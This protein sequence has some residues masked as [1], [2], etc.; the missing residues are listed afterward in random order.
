VKLLCVHPGASFSTADVYNGLTPALA[1][2]GHDI[3][4]YRLDWRINEATEIIGWRERRRKKAQGAD[5]QELPGGPMPHIIRH[6][7]MT[8]LEATLTVNPH[9]LLIFSAMF[10]H[11]EAMILLRR[12]GVPTV[13]LLTESP[14]DDAKQANITPFAS[15]VYTNERASVRLMRRWHEQTGGQ[16]GARQIDYLPHAYDPSVH[17]PSDSDRHDDADI[18]AHDVVFVGS[19]FYERQEVLQAVDWEGLY[20]KWPYVGSRNRLRRYIRGGVVPNAVTA[21][22]YRRARI[23]LNLYRQSVGTS[24]N[25]TR[26]VG[27]ESLNPRALELAATATPHISDWRPEVEEVFGDTVPTFRNA[28]EL[29]TLIRSLMRPDADSHLSRMRAELPDR[30]K[31]WTFDDRAIQVERGIEL[32]RSAQP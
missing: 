20:G 5:Y 19:G 28:R 23:G 22:L 7:S 9:C 2:R 18:P 27:A 10:L 26:I 6:A 31:G 16:R 12:M 25:A 30:V 24:R 21:A 14:Y 4:E 15:M 32:A 8:L 29:E 11:P 1:R 13:L 3:Q 17:H